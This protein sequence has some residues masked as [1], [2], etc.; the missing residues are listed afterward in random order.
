MS[1]FPD[2]RDWH[3][4]ARRKRRFRSGHHLGTASGQDTFA[5][6]DAGDDSPPHFVV[7]GGLVAIVHFERRGVVWAGGE[8]FAISRQGQRPELSCAQMDDVGGG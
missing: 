3:R 6:R 7:L 1:I 5:K 4:S 2:Q 8:V